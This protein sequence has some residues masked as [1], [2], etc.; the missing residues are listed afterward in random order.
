MASRTLSVAA[1]VSR[2]T[3]VRVRSVTVSRRHAAASCGPRSSR[4]SRVRCTPATDDPGLLAV[5]GLG[6]Q[7]GQVGV[8]PGDPG[9]VVPQALVGDPPGQLPRV[10][11]RPPVP[12]PGRGQAQMAGGIAEPLQVVPGG[13]GDRAVQVG[14]EVLPERDRPLCLADTAPVQGAGLEQDPDHDGVGVRLGPRVGPPP[15]HRGQRRLGAFQVPRQRSG[16]PGQVALEP[17][18]RQPA[19]EQVD[20]ALPVGQAGPEGDVGQPGGALR[21]VRLGQV[22][23]RLG[24]RPEHRAEEIGEDVA[25]AVPGRRRDPAPR[26]VRPAGRGDPGARGELA[27][28][29][30]GDVADAV[31]DLGHQRLFGAVEG[32]DHAQRGDSG[33]PGRRHRADRAGR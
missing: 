23:D 21:D 26:A 12:E 30:R 19:R 22:G 4:A 14:R 5:P 2:A 15:G 18:R 25:P 17:Q 32:D 33:R 8:G 13:V 24:A 1:P 10:G 31:A 16:Q 27:F 20:R 3:S 7:R 11:R 28:L 9:L 29:R 6:G